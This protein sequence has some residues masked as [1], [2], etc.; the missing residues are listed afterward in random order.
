MNTVSVFPLGY[1]NNVG[2]ISN[3]DP[4]HDYTTTGTTQRKD[5]NSIHDHTLESMNSNNVGFRNNT[6][7]TYDDSTMCTIHG[8]D[9]NLETAKTSSI[10]EHVESMC[11]KVWS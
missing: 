9:T 11:S 2:F 8:K 10:L 5:A 6:D 3:T 1:S 7:P 4:T